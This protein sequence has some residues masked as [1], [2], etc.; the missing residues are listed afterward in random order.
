MLIVSEFIVNPKKSSLTPT[1]DLVYVY[2]GA[3]FH[4]DLGRLNLL[5]DRVD[6]LLAHVR[7]FS[8]LR[9]YKPSLLF[10][11]LLGV[12]AATLSSVEYTCLRMRSIQWYMKHHWNQVT[13]GL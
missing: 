6:G 5:E 3:R 4:T 2:I 7:F 8:R 13:H 12:M 11:S 9:H 1:H 10:L